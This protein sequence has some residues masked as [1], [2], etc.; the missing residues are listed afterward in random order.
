[1]IHKCSVSVSLFETLLLSLKGLWLIIKGE[2]L[3]NQMSSVLSFL[4]SV[5]TMPSESSFKKQI[6]LIRESL[7]NFSAVRN[8][9]APVLVKAAI[10]DLIDATIALNP[11]IPYFLS[12]DLFQELVPAA[13]T[14]LT[15]FAADYPDFLMP[16]SMEKVAGLKGRV[17]GSF[18]QVIAKKSA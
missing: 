15:K 8:L 3:F 6:E 10:N 5:F 18:A 4:L 16:K 2:F 7:K 11:Y 13:Y 1:M 14:S 17:D 12:H 9:K